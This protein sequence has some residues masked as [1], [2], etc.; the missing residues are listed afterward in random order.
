MKT[1]SFMEVCMQVIKPT[2]QEVFDE[3]RKNIGCCWLGGAGCQCCNRQ[4]GQCFKETEN[5]LTRTILTGDEIKAGQARNA[6]AM[7]EIEDML[8][9]AFGDDEKTDSATER[10]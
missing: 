5:N 2:K 6:A 3:L 8:N 9:S 4:L 10:F 1:I 7:K